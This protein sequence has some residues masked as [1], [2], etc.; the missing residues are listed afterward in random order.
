M[1]PAPARAGGTAAAAAAARE[2]GTITRQYP[3]TCSGA[4]R[5]V[6]RKYPTTCSGVK[7]GAQWICKRFSGRL[8]F[9]RFE[10]DR[11]GRHAAAG[12]TT[13]WLREEHNPTNRVTGVAWF[14]EKT[15]CRRGV[16]SCSGF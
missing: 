14:W 13:S 10:L 15:P 2:A 4:K 1:P 3:T 12:A 16:V 7:G 11:A 6:T 8:S 9:I 5:G